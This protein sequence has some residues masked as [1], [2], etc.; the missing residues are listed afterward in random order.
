MLAPPLLLG[1]EKAIVAV[2][3]PA[4]AEEMVGDPGTVTVVLPEDPEELVLLLPPPP[5]AAIDKI[6]TLTIELGTSFA[7]WT[8]ITLI[9]AE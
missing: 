7:D 6:N 9:L 8:F 2:P 1:A 3:S 5:Q 4:V